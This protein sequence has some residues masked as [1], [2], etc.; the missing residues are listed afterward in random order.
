MQ[1]LESI[2]RDI[3]LAKVGRACGVRHQAVMYWCRVGLPS[4]PGDAARRAEFERIIARMAGMK[5][6]ELR[7]IIA[8]EEGRAA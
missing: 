2:L 1:T 3:G 7:S 6:G 8:K 4:R 5:V